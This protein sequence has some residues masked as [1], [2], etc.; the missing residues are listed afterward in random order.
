MRLNIF[1]N[2]I[3]QKPAAAFLAIIITAI[4]FVTLFLV[5]IIYAADSDMEQG[6]P[7]YQRLYRIESQF[8][9]PNGDT[10]RSAQIPLPLV[11]AL[12]K[13]ADIESVGYAF[14]LEAQLHRQTHITPRVT[15]F[16]VTPVF[17][18]QLH[19]FRHPLPAPGPH[20]IYITADFNRQY[21]GLADPLGK[22]VDLGENGQFTIK[23]IVEPRPDS[24]LNLSAIIAFTPEQIAGYNDKRLDW[25][26][27]HAYAFARLQPSVSHFDRQIL[28][29]IVTHN[30]PQLPG[31]PFTPS[32]FLTFSA[33]NI[34]DIHYDNDYADEFVA[35]RAR[36]LLY[37]LY[38][39]T[40]FVLLSTAANFFTINGILNAA[41]RPA[42][43]VKCSLGASNIQILAE[44]L[45]VFLPQFLA[46]VSLAI[47]FLGILFPL[48]SD[49]SELLS[50][51][52]LT[53]LITVF[54]GTALLTGLIMLL[55]HLLS[56]SLFIFREQTS[57]TTHRYENISTYYL[58]RIIM[59]IQMMVTGI[60]LYLYAGMMTQNYTAMHTDFGY[61]KNQRLT[62]SL[63]E[64]FYSLGSVRELQHRLQETA[65]AVTISLSSWQPFNMSRQILSVQHAKQS[66][67]DQFTP[68]NALS[69]D[70]YFVDVW[71]LTLLAGQANTLQASSDKRICHAVVTRAFMQAM[72]LKTFDEVLNTRYYI[73]FPEGLQEFRVLQIVEDFDLGKHLSSPQPLIIFINDRL[74]KFATLS[75]VNE[76][77][78]ALLVKLLRRYGPPGLS[79]HSVQTLHNHHFHNDRQ[80]LNIITLTTVLS[81]IL[82]VISTLV[83][84]I[85]EVQRLNNTLKI[86]EAVGGSRATSLVFFLQQNV[87]P[88]LLAL[89]IALVAGCLLLRR[90]LE[91]YESVTGLPYINAF[92]ALLLLSLLVTAIM[93]LS[94]VLSSRRGSQSRLKRK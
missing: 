38:T 76:Q 33:K 26:D 92:A 73:P 11:E 16:A 59:M 48:S 55:S 30:A 20:D 42:Q 39:A 82:M 69:A 52:S 3:R 89:L 79:V 41:R 5:L 58:N 50:H 4:S 81:L 61:Q 43:S 29:Q 78:E 23:A 65:G 40:L 80:M 14:R 91:Q 63:D 18:E 1:T 34:I 28:T 46:T 72:G 27:T 45:S 64:E 71:G 49:I 6:T 75:Y 2:D 74:E 62:F 19:P 24:S 13:N 54:T 66:I 9:L 84:G 60:A 32:S 35:T 68:I 22:T 83:I 56:L 85:S 44:S 17:M 31:S 51:Q 70:K 25:Y 37:I 93:T 57:R 21:L 7:E 90:W 47:F 8:N 67:H 15:V 87:L 77:N 36:S 10:V 53:R 88:M 12:Q 94:L 86:M